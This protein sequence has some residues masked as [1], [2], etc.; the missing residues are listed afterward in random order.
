MFLA[1]FPSLPAFLLAGKDTCLCGNEFRY[2]FLVLI[3]KWVELPEETAMEQ[4]LT[5]LQALTRL[6]GLLH[7][8][9]DEN[10]REISFLAS[11]LCLATSEKSIFCCLV[12]TKFRHG[13]PKQ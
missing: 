8:P 1:V 6:Y 9:A 7:S 4:I 13:K 12:E 2:S 5:D 11:L 3:S 10:V